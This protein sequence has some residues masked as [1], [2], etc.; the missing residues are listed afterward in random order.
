MAA[1]SRMPSSYAEPLGRGF[2]PFDRECLAA[3]TVVPPSVGREIRIRGG[4]YIERDIG[5]E[6]PENSAGPPRVE[7]TGHQKH[8]FRARFAD[9]RQKRSRLFHRGKRVMF[10]MHEVRFGKS[11]LHG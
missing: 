6:F 8:A 4:D 7:V 3:F 1:E 10:G 2:H 5:R 9:F 11:M